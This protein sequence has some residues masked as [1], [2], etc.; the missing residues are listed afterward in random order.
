[1]W[2]SHVNEN[3]TR[4]ERKKAK[5]IDKR[6]RTG[7]DCANCSAGTRRL[8]GKCETLAICAALKRSAM[9]ARDGDHAGVETRCGWRSAPA[10]SRPES[11]KFVLHPDRHGRSV[12]HRR[13]RHSMFICLKQCP[14]SLC[15]HRPRPR[16]RCFSTVLQLQRQP[17]PLRLPQPC[18]C[19]RHR[20]SARCQARAGP[21]LPRHRYA[22]V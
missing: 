16:P 18:A 17:L 9:V 11:F 5:Q 15:R 19:S 7:K 22:A 1:M 3:E 14:D 2:G 13:R 12:C 8:A 20:L 10:V 6:D 4:K 21:A